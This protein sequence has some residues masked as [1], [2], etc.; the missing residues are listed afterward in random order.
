VTARGAHA[1]AA[2]STVDDYTY[3]SGGGWSS[4]GSVNLTLA[5]N[6]TGYINLSPSS[7][8]SWANAST[9]QDLVFEAPSSV[10][11]DYYWPTMTVYFSDRAP[12]FNTQ[13]PTNQSNFDSMGDVSFSDTATDPDHDDTVS[14]RWQLYTFDGTTPFDDSGWLSAA[15]YEPPAGSLEWNTWYRYEESISV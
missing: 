12:V 1:A 8:Q 9:Y 14:H 5:S 15:H 13:S 3:A 2:G 10:V 11:G 6:P 4:L 7:V